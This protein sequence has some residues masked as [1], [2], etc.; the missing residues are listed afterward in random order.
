MQEKY[1]KEVKDICVFF[2]RHKIF[3]IFKTFCRSW[4]HTR[5]VFRLCF[6]TSKYRSYCFIVKLKCHTGGFK[7]DPDMVVTKRMLKRDQQ[8]QHCQTYGE[9]S[10]ILNQNG[11]VKVISE[12]LKFGA[13]KLFFFFNILVSPFQHHKSPL[14]LFGFCLFL[15]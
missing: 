5:L 4:M 2:S 11:F 3:A 10:N 8:K 1:Q 13:F 6:T 12:K 7:K 15:F 14:F 9:I